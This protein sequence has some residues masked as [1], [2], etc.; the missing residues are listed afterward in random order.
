MKRC[1]Q[2][3]GHIAYDPDIGWWEGCVTLP[4]GSAFLVYVHTP[5]GN[6]QS[7]TEP[8]RAAF[9]KMKSSEEA[10]RQFAAA[11]LLSIHNGMWN[12]GKQ[13]DAN[14]F[15]TRLLPSAIEVWPDGAAEISFG[16]DDLFWGHEVGVR[17]RGGRFTE[18]VVQ[19]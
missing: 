11:E 6:D 10:A 16:D 14:E 7:I 15:V 3:L 4:S 8:A 2:Q 18:A 1:D 9:E 13:I 19:G 17:Y 12:V 5:G